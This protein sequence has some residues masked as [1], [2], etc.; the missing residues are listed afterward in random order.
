MVERLFS[1]NKRENHAHSGDVCA[2]DDDI[3][4]GAVDV[5]L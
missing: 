3:H 1:N 5:V 2:R 4:P